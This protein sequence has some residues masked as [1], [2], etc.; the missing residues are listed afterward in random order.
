MH[1]IS[2]LHEQICTAISLAKGK[3]LLYV[4]VSSFSSPS[5][6]SLGGSHYTFPH[7][8]LFVL[9]IFVARAV[10]QAIQQSS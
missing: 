2:A 3:P 6:S 4:W 8:F 10:A 5:A 7:N 9:S 1:C